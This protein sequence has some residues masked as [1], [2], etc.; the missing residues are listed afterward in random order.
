[1]GVCTPAVPIGKVKTRTGFVGAYLIH[2]HAAK[3][4]HYDLRIEMDGVLKSWA[5]PKEPSMDPQVKRLAVMVDDHALSYK[6]FEGTIKDGSYGAGEVKIWDH[7]TYILNEI[8]STK[9]VF[10]IQGK[11]LSGEFCLLYFPKA[12]EKN[13]L[14]FKKK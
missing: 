12:G 2:D 7:G 5:I 11:K 9:I 13:W 8:S 1:M 3:K 4:H 6:N 10:T 14:F